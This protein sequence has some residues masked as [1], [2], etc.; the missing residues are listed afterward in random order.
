VIVVGLIV[1]GATVVKE[2]SK[3]IVPNSISVTLP[4]PVKD[5]T[6]E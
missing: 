6:N 4:T 3:S 1:V 2:D 5:A